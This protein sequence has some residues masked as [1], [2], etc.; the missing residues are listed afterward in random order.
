AATSIAKLLAGMADEGPPPV[1]AIVPRDVVPFHESLLQTA[2]SKKAAA[3]ASV[4]VTLVRWPY[5]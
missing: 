1:P 2:S 3:P 4:T 5:T